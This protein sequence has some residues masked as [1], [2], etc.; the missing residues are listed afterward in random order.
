MFFKLQYGIFTFS[1]ADIKFPFFI[2]FLTDMYV[3]CNND[4]YVLYT[5]YTLTTAVSEW[6]SVLYSVLYTA[7]PTIIVAIFDKD[8][9]RR[10]LL[11]YPKLY[12]SGQREERYNKKLFVFCMMESVWQSLVI[13]YIPYFVYRRSTIDVSSLG[14]IW[15]V[16]AVIVVNCHLALDVV[17]WN[18]VIHAFIWGTIAA[19]AICVVVLDS[20][21]L[22][23]GYW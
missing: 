19:T 6:S 16:A 9:S 5:A 2:E 7:L 20:I 10:T 15:T 3:M 4:R 23:P 17:R 22:L 14:D 18:W 12:G 11:K 1:R 21:W 8:L 13:F